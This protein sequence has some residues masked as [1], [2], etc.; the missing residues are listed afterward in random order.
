MQKIIV[1][2][3]LLKLGLFIVE[4]ENYFLLLSFLLLCVFPDVESISEIKI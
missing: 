1:I 3:L 4:K 2:E